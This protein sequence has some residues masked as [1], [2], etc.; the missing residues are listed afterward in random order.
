MKE[1]LRFNQ[2]KSLWR[3]FCPQAFEG[4]LDVLEYGAFKYS[5]FIASNTTENDD[6]SEGEE[7]TGLQLMQAGIT[8]KDVERWKWEMTRSGADQWKDGL[9]ITACLESLLR[10]VFA[11]KEGEDLDQESGLSHI[12]HAMCNL[13]F[14]SYYMLFK[15]KF[16]DRLKMK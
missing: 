6:F 16:D 5:I 3:Y 10:H 2:G 15:P 12:S 9:S 11:F 1:A 8:R 13:M 4:M 7:V 14:I